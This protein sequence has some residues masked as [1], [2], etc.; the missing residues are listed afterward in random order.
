MNSNPAMT[1][2]NVTGS[3]GAGKTTYAKKLGQQLNLPVH[4]LDAIVWQPHWQKT[5]PAKRRQ[6]EGKITEAP[7]WVVDG[8]S[9][10]VREQADLVI[11]M[12]VPWPRCLAQALKR[13][14]PYMFRSRPG[15]PEH[16]PELLILPTLVRMIL[17]YP[18]TLK[19]VLEREARAS[20]KYVSLANA[21]DHTAILGMVCGGAGQQIHRPR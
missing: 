18:T 4:H 5:P 3:A 11:V 2:I 17:E 15:L 13:N 12:D 1:K 7:C 10:H 20:N 6:L 19:P 14:L 21:D 9:K 16:C 8:V